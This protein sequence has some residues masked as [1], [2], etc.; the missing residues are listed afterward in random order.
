MLQDDQFFCWRSV[1]KVCIMAALHCDYYPD[2]PHGEDED[3]CGEPLFT[4]IYK[5]VAVKFTFT[6]TCK[7]FYRNLLTLHR[8]I[9]RLLDIILGKYRSCGVSFVLLLFSLLFHNL[10]ST[11]RLDTSRLKIQCW[12]LLTF[13][14]QMRQNVLRHT[15]TWISVHLPSFLCSIAYFFLTF[16]RSM[17]IWEGPVSM[18]RHQRWTEQ[19]E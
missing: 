18:D 19:V 13:D 14:S 15:E 3:G 12:L 11:S 5:R 4:L 7:I 1:E 10:I 2:C 8:L 9:Y 16:F 6:E 17:H